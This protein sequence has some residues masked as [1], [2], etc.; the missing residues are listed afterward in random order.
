MHTVHVRINDAA[1]GKPTPCRVRFTD[2]EGRTYA[3]FGRLTEFATGRNQDVGGNVL[4]GM[5]PYAFIDGTCE[6]RLPAGLIHVEI[7]KG[8]EFLPQRLQ[9]ALGPGQLALRFTL[10]RWV[11]PR[12]DAWF[13][14]D[15]RCH[16]LTP[17]AALLEAAAE[18]LAVVNLLAEMCQVPGPFR[19]EFPAIPN[20]LS[21]SGQQ[22]ALESPGHLV[23]VNTHNCHP[24]LG[25]LGLL[26]CHRVVYPLRFGGPDGFE[27]WAMADW[28]DQCHRKGGL[29]VW[30][31]TAH[32]AA[33]FRFGEPL[34]DLILGKVDAFEIDAF[35]DSPFDVLPDW[36]GLL[37]CGLRVPLA[38]S[39]G[40]DN[41]GM[42][43]GALRMYARLQSGEAFTYKNWIEAVRAGRT[44]VTNGPLVG[45]RVNDRE[46][47]ETVQLAVDSPTVHV[48]AEAKSI[49]P[50]D[51]LEVIV[52]GTIV[53][54]T[55]ASGSPTTA[56]LETDVPL[57][58]SGWLAARCRGEPQ[59]LHR[60]ANQRV[61]AHTSPVYVQAEGRPAAFD[62][63]ARNRFVAELEGMLAWVAQ[64]ARCEQERQRE[65]L[66]EI[67]QA[68]R[69]ELLRRGA[70]V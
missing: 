62:L 51:R 11:N 66:A 22:P 32:E 25:N 31:K 30:T 42:L 35:E 52:N 49:V 58:S 8:P 26:N 38:G 12:E 23:V 36:Y 56:V 18:D 47:G 4:I 55:A 24:V 64:E 2:A 44:F 41:N 3:P 10:A 69:Q 65:H 63:A 57:S 50:F 20:L 68:A 27:D 37:N 53:A 39:S 40:K 59:L 9:V 67:I 21:F 70:T 17:H 19:R 61:F 60:P 46:Q 15:G 5:K 43:L 1:T 48:R 7:H 13:S 14:G 45:L 54:D 34:A 33:G 16:Y 6:I 29:V 28:C